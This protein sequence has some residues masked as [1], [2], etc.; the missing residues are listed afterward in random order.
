[1]LREVLGILLKYT[2]VQAINPIG[3]KP[4]EG[5][6]APADF[7]FL[8]RIFKAFS[9]VIKSLREPCLTNCVPAIYSHGSTKGGISPFLRRSLLLGSAA[10]IARN[11]SATDSAT[12]VAWSEIAFARLRK[13]VSSCERYGAD[14]V[15][16]ALV[17]TV[18]KK[19]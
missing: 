13:L 10:S 1:V 3:Q 14:S 16:R 18:S 7:H 12:E 9:I 6:C 5:T 2:L 19:P 15:R 8:L 11:L 17:T 4:Q